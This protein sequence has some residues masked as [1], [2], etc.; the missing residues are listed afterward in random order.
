MLIYFSLKNVISTKDVPQTLEWYLKLEEEEMH[1]LDKTESVHSLVIQQ[2]YI[3]F[4]FTHKYQE[5]ER[6]NISLEHIFSFFGT[7][8]KFN[9]TYSNSWGWI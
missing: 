1:L 5:R 6:E 8:Y 3:I 4:K 2:S 7:D 9:P